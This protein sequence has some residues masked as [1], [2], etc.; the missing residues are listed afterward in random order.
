[1]SGDADGLCPTCRGHCDPSPGYKPKVALTAPDQVRV[2]IV[3][4]LG[5]VVL[6][7]HG[8]MDGREVGCR[9]VAEAKAGLSG[10]AF[11]RL[12]PGLKG[13]IHGR[14]DECAKTSLGYPVDTTGLAS[15]SKPP[16]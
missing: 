15:S 6:S 14:C 2:G 4:P 3:R 13:T 9:P 5:H 1:M 10:Y 7:F 12:P 11:V 16:G 8:E